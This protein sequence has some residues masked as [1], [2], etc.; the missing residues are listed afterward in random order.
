MPALSP[1]AIDDLAAVRFYIEQ[2]GPAAAQ[3]VALRI[4]HKLWI[5]QALHSAARLSRLMRAIDS[6]AFE[7]GLLSTRSPELAAHNKPTHHLPSGEPKHHVG[8]AFAFNPY[9][10]IGRNDPC[11]CGSGRKFRK[12][13]LPGRA[14][15]LSAA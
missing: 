10:G 12:C 9:K 5:L 2:D 14:D 6:G 7:L 13:C 4:I 11:P 8:P 3:R 15:A 1:E